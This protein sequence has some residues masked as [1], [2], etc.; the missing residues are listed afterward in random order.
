MKSLFIALPEE[1]H[2]TPIVHTNTSIH[3]E[4][5]HLYSTVLRSKCH[6]IFREIFDFYRIISGK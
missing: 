3:S 6:Q 1:H 4:P 2:D 5:F